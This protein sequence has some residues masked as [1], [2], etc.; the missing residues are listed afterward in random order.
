MTVPP[1]VYGLHVEH[2]ELPAFRLVEQRFTVPPAIDVAMTLDKEW[3]RLRE[4]VR[5]T[6]GDE[7]A[8]AVGSRGIDRLSEIVGD[9]VG[10]LREAGCRPF[11]VPAMGSHGGGKRRGSARL[12]AERGITEERVGAPIRATMEV[13]QVGEAEGLPLFVDRLAQA[14]A[15][16]VLINRIKPHTDFAGPAGSGLLKMLCVGLG[17]Q[18]G[19]DLYHRAALAQD[20]GDSSRAAVANCWQ[21]CRSSSAPQ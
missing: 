21:L 9:V 4:G 19:A 10:K 8:V 13:V 16:I 12:L 18:V 1:V 11:I 7:I 3:R 15:G 5:L 6:P 14:A 17:N 20:L 2:P